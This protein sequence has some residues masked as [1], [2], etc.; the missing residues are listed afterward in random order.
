MKII[1]N[2]D[3]FGISD[4][5]VD[6]TIDLFEKGI[7]NSATILLGMPATG[8]AIEYAKKNTQFSYGIHLN[9]VDEGKPVLSPQVVP[10]LVNKKG[11]FYPSDAV[12]KS[13]L[14]N[15]FS[16][17]EISLETIEQ[18]NYL[19]DNGVPVS[20]IDSHGHIH[21]LPT[22]AKAI[23]SVKKYLGISKIRN[24]QNI[25]TKRSIL[26]WSF[27]LNSLLEAN[28]KNKFETTNYF[29]MSSHFENLN[30]PNLFK[31]IKNNE[32][33]E[34]GFHPGYIEDWRIHESKS[35][36]QLSDFIQKNSNFKKIKWNEL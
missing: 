15:K 33:L 2:A 14:L 13:L 20:H 29:F 24:V 3:D 25:F 19:K 34:V 32:S 27:W 9:F 4:D 6:A 21:K 28:I 12:R 7:L 36:K 31:E 18:V 17:L 35:A 22:F 16:P 11:R 23:F 26:S 1:L 10:S 5:T 8:R 30:W